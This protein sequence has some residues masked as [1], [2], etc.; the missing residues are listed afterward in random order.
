MTLQESATRVRKTIDDASPYAMCPV[1]LMQAEQG[2]VAA[3]WMYS[4]ALQQARLI[5]A[6]EEFARAWSPSVN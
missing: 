3:H 2:G 5:V 1:A 6:G 4:Y